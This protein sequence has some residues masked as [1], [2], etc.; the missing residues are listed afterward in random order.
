MSTTSLGQPSYTFPRGVHPPE[1]KGLSENAS[2]E[3]LPIPKEIRIPLLQHLGAPCNPL[4][5]AK[6]EVAIG[7]KVGE[8]SGFVSSPVHSS[9]A[10]VVAR[11]KSVTLPNGRRVASIPIKAADEQPL[12]GD[13][14][15]EDVFGGDWPMDGADK[16]EP[17]QIADAAK[18]GG[19]VGLGGAA[20]PTHVKLARNDAKP[21]EWLLLNGCEC[22]P[23]LTS[24]Y[25]LMVEAPEPVISGAILAGR[26]VGADK[27]AVCV[28]DNKPEAIKRLAAAATGTAVEVRV[29]KT[30][31]PQGGERQL[32]Y[33]ALGRAVPVGGLPLDVGVVVMNV[34][35]SAALARA[36]Y[37]KKPLTHRIVSVSG[38]GIAEPKNLLVPIGTSYQ[39]LVDYCGGLTAD[40]SRIVAGGPMMG[41]TLGSLDTPVTKGTS[42][43][44]VLTEEECRRS[45]E[46]NCVRCGRCVDCCPQ[47]LVPTKL[48]LSARAGA[49]DLLERYSINACIECGSCAYVCPACLPLVQLIRA[50]KTALR[51]KQSK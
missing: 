6:A 43:I 19:L 32:I 48:A 14:L 28:E 30:K 1:N 5:K 22:E 26:A 15:F 24:D 18:E 29:M 16:I 25:R 50:G 13:A 51:K 45:V 36:V 49:L 11:A 44:T 20:F 23:Y 46:T 40:A 4:L 17:G 42:G 10:G 2:I 47:R 7:D 35:T 37:R 3:V 8:A 39:A 12:E 33:A 41:F 27:V 31:Y 9:V 21:I 34:G 38:G